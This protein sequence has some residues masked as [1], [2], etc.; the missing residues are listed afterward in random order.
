MAPR[1]G[2]RVARQPAEGAPLQVLQSGSR[3]P[4]AALLQGRVIACRLCPDQPPEA[5]GLA[6][7][8]QLVPRVVDDLEEE[9]RR[10]AALVQL[11]RREQVPRA[12]GPGYDA[13]GLRPG[14]PRQVENPLARIRR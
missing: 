6:R 7:N 8:R 12:E 9:P 14:P 11:A 13:A 10:R 5:E 1:S 4:P 3:D 2:E